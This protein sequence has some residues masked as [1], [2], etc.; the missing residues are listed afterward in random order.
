[1]RRGKIANART[2]AKILMLRVET[3]ME[4]GKQKF[5][6]IA[7]VHTGSQTGELA[8]VDRILVRVTQPASASN[9]GSKASKAAATGSVDAA[10]GKFKTVVADAL[11]I[12]EGL[13]DTKVALT[14][15]GD[16]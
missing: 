5:T 11:L 2:I 14:V 6:A 1:M 16:R 8:P 7:S 9:S 10:D 12:T 13:E 4:G 3:R 15:P